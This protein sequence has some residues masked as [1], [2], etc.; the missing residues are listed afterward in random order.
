[1]D[2]QRQA[3]QAGVGSMESDTPLELVPE[4]WC[5]ESSYVNGKQKYTAKVLVFLSNDKRPQ[6]QPPTSL[7]N[8]N[9]LET[10]VEDVSSGRQIPNPNKT[11]SAQ[12]T[13]MGS[14]ADLLAAL[15]EESFSGEKLKL[16]A[17]ASKASYTINQVSQLLLELDFENDRLKALKMLKGA[18]KDPQNAKSLEDLF[19]FDANKKQVRS[20]L[21]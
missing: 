17:A 4:D 13:Q 8:D 6:K 9:S 10:A 20:I 16:I 11:T 2:A 5:I 19:D 1:M 21:Q 15:K 18:I 14:F 12:P 7:T 3:F